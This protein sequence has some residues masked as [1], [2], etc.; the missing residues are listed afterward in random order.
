VIDKISELIVS[1]NINK[2]YK[3]IGGDKSKYGNCHDFMY[4]ILDTLEIEPK[5]D[6]S[7]NKFIKNLREKGKTKLELFI[8]EKMKEQFGIKEKKIIFTSHV[9]LDEFVEKLLLK[10]T[11]FKTKYKDEWA[12]LKAFDRA[13][14]VR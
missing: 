13:F 2:S 10:E 7:L 8:D 3:I 14:W 4:S 11:E 6:K 9:Q 1:W 12:L 5:F